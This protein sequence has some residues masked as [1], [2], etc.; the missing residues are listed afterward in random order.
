MHDENDSEHKLPKSTP[1]SLMFDEIT[2]VDTFVVGL[3]VVFSFVLTTMKAGKT[4]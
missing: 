4:T 1:K 3:A 2:W